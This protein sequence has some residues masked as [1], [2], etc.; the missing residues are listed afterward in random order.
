MVRFSR[1]VR[2]SSTA[3]YWPASPIRSR[4]LAASRTTSRPATSIVPHRAS[5]AWSGSARTVVLPAPLGPS[6]PSTVPVRT[7]RSTPQRARTD[8]NDLT[9]PRTMMAESERAGAGPVAS[10]LD[11]VD[12]VSDGT[13]STGPINPVAASAG[14][15]PPAGAAGRSRRAPAPSLDS[16]RDA[17]RKADHEGADEGRGDQQ[18]QGDPQHR[19]PD[20]GAEGSPV[21]GHRVNS[22]AQRT[23]TLSSAADALLDRRDG[24]NASFRCVCVSGL[25]S[26]GLTCRRVPGRRAAGRPGGRG[27][28][29]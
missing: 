28:G 11:T 25:S 3:A 10:A 9:S 23:P 22:M 13:G 26:A 7:S 18:Q 14:T 19:Q 1:P 12:T 16:S 15:L 4:S 17:D 2:F 29:C 24:P 20:R 5:A 21:S 27:G 8:P 6:R